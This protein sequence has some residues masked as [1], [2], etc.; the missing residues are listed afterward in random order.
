MARADSTFEGLPVP[1]SRHR[2]VNYRAPMPV[3]ER[4]TR[5][6][7]LRW[8]LLVG[9]S[10]TIVLMVVYVGWWIYF[11]T[12][13]AFFRPAVTCDTVTTPPAPPRNRNRSEP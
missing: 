8:G 10:S 1:D 5:S 13:L 4:S 12:P 6:V 7:S 11:G 9:A 3:T 2:A